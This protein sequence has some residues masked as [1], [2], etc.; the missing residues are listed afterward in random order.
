MSVALANSKRRK[1]KPIGSLSITLT[2]LVYIAMLLFMGAAAMNTQTPL[3]FIIFGLMIGVM[4]AGGVISQW[5]LRRIQIRRDVPDSATVGQPLRIE[6]EVDNRKSFW[7]ALSLTLA[8][9]DDAEAFERQPHGYL[10]HAAGSQKALVHAS[11]TPL[12]RGPVR[13]ERFQI[14]TS[15]PF[16]FVKRAAFRRERDTVLVRPAQ[17]TVDP[18]AMTRLLSA[19]SSGLNQRPRPGGYDEFYGTRDYRPGD[20]IRMI[21]WRRSART[22]GGATPQRAGGSL[23][24][25]QMTRVAPP[26]LL[27]CV[28]TFAPSDADT[29]ALIDIERNLATAAS[30]LAAATRRGLAVGLIMAGEKRLTEILPDRTKRGRRDLMA[31]LAEAP[32]NTD[33]PAGNLVSRAATVSPNDTT[34]MLITAGEGHPADAPATRPSA[35]GRGTIRR[36]NVVTILTRPGQVESWVRFDDEL[37]WEAMIA[38]EDA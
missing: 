10:L 32:R 24:V 1:V 21:H 38:R 28:D 4:L 23:V 9:L 12:R 2:G 25:K 35:G 7:P 29:P 19:E 22:G 27:L 26:R 18:V 6:Y 30:I 15:F 37:D 16:G 11:A 13:L 17:G 33:V 34:V 5:V 36:G 3:L 14:S 31:V 20:P 8:E